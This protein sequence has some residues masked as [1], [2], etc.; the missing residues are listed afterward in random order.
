M[1]LARYQSQELMVFL[2]SLEHK[3]FTGVLHL[4]ASIDSKGKQ[5]Q[6]VIILNSGKITYGGSKIPDH[7]EF[8]DTILKKLLKANLTDAAINFAKKRVTNQDSIREFLECFVKM[9]LFKWEN[10]ESLVTNKV[11]TILEQLLPYSGQVRYESNINFDLCYGESYQGLSWLKIDTELEKR[12][13]E[14]KALAPTIPSMDAIPLLSPIPL[15]RISDVTVSQHLD[16]WVDHRRSLIDIAEA[17]DKDPLQ[18]AKVYMNWVQAGWMF[19]AETNESNDRNTPTVSS[20]PS[21]SQDL[22]TILCIDDSPIIQITIKR[23]LSSQYK[24][25]IASNAVDGLNLLYNQPISL[26]L[27]DVSMPDIDGLE[28]CRTVRK[29]PKFKDLPIL[30]LTAKDGFVDKLKGQFVGA[31]EYL[32]KPFE[33]LQLLQIVDGYVNRVSQVNK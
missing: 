33:P 14:W 22:P 1:Q 12:Q 29:I 19:F 18:I 16:K 21:Q 8:I 7:Q 13:Q 30:M 10:L 31:T 25:L 32:I 20:E 23:A 17:L 27:L 4:E 28:L 24:V 2:K 3:Q 11:V 9:Q 5:K 15:D 6:Q 26:V